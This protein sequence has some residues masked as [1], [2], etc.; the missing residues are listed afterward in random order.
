M[1]AVFWRSDDLG[2]F[3]QNHHT[4]LDAFSRWY[5]G[6]GVAGELLAIGHLLALGHLRLVL[7]LVLWWG[8]VLC[9][10]VLGREGLHLLGWW[11]K[12]VRRMLVL[13]WGPLKLL[14]KLLEWT[15]RLL[16]RS[17]LH[18]VTLICEQSVKFIWLLWR[19]RWSLLRSCLLIFGILSHILIY[20]FK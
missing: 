5:K 17:L 16:R 12:L 14:V 4:G 2:I 18:R 7:L 10:L 8:W 9:L 15:F 13:L 19:L 1:L 11:Y 3:V 20:L 6:F